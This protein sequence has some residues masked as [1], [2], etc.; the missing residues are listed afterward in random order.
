MN[1]RMARFGFREMKALNSSSETDLR[2]VTLIC[3]NQQYIDDVDVN[4]K[5]TKTRFLKFLDTFGSTN[6]RKSA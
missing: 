2:K 6:Y 1:L 4:E 5:M 3:G